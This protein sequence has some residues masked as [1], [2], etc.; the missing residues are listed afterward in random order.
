MYTYHDITR[1]SRSTKNL[2]GTILLA[3]NV[4][5]EGFSKWQDYKMS[6]ISV[7]LLFS[8]TEGLSS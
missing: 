2:K 6:Q 4:A 7:I 8:D 1:T 3:P 5:C